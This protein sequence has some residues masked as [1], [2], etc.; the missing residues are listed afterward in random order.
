MDGFDTDPNNFAGTSLACGAIAVAPA[1]HDIIYVG[2]GEGDADHI[3]R[4]RLTNALPAYRGIGPIVSDDGG[5]SSGHKSS[6]P[7]LTGFA[8]YDLSVDPLHSDNVIQPQQMAY[9][10]EL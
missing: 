4:S 3:F 6:S 5:D 10:N 8:F 7:P 1:N 9:I 2:T